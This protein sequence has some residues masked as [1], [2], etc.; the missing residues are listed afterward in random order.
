VWRQ[1]E[2][3]TAVHDVIDLA[4]AS[5][6]PRS[7]PLLSRV[8]LDGKAVA[9]APRLADLRARSRLLIAELPA[10][11]RRIRDPHP[12]PVSLGDAL[13]SALELASAR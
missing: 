5:P 11:V 3:D 10:A 9:P 6:Y 13:R 4:D 1:F 8:M 7:R 2:A 12:Y